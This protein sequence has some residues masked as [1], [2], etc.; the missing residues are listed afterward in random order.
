MVGWDFR[1]DERVPYVHKSSKE[2]RSEFQAEERARAATAKAERIKAHFE[3]YSPRVKVSHRV[4][5]PAPLP[6]KYIGLGCLA[7]TVV[8]VV[9]IVVLSLAVYFT[10]DAEPEEKKGEKKKRSKASARR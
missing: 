1:T 9:A 5:V 3:R 7:F 10:K 4:F 6:W 8:V 2:F